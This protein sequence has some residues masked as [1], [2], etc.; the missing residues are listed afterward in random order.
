MLSGAR[1][2]PDEVES[3]ILDGVS[4]QIRKFETMLS[5]IFGEG[6]VEKRMNSDEAVSYGAAIFGAQRGNREENYD[7]RLHNAFWR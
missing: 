7:F 3:V 6:I 1:R 4:S 2:E 5:E